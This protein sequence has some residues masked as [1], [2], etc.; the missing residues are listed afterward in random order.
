SAIAALKRGCGFVG[1]DVDPAAIAFAERRV[2]AYLATGAD[3][4]QPRS[5]L[6]ENESYPWLQPRPD[7]ARTAQSGTLPEAPNAAASCAS[8]E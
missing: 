3:P 2:G 5:A 4:A 7:G 1:C 8:R 6:L